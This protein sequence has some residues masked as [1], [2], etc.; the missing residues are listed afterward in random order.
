MTSKKKVYLLEIII[1]KD[2]FLSVE[3]IGVYSSLQLAKQNKA[4]IEEVNPQLFLKD[5]SHICEL[6]ITPIIMNDK[7]AFFGDPIDIDEVV[8][9]LMEKGLVDQLI[10]EDGNFYYVL[11]DLGK[12][13][14]A[15]V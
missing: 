12:I 9:G 5:S 2:G 1:V 10:G 7:P 6:C 14:R 13:G 8:K 4:L 15:H 3:A 11:T